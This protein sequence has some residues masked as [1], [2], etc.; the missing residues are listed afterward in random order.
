MGRLRRL[1]H[2]GVK[3]SDIERSMA[4]YRDVLGL[5]VSER[6]DPGEAPGYPG[7]CLMR[8]KGD[9]HHVNLIYGPDWAGRESDTGGNDNLDVG[10]HHFAFEVDTR[11]DFDAMLEEMKT[12]GVEIVMGPVKHSTTAPDG[13]G[14]WGENRS[15]YIVDPDKNRIEICCE[16]HQFDD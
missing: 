12:K 14:S 8:C 1:Q 2:I 15:F 9:H 3:V 16:M 11:E 7:L 6:H 4:W 10:I 13:D 5:T